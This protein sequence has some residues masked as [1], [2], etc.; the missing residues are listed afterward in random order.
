M[1]ESDTQISTLLYTAFKDARRF[2]FEIAASYGLTPAQLAAL[3]S[4]WKNDGMKNTELGDQLSLK[5]STVTTLADRME[6]DGLVI[7]KRSSA[8]R[9][10]VNIWLTPKG[11]ELKEMVPDIEK[12]VVKKMKRHFN[13]EEF[14]ELARLLQK[15]SEALAKTDEQA[16]ST[17]K[18]RGVSN[19]NC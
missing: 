5:T 19:G 10:A 13:N 9:R 15:F 8:D 4:L 17:W 2:F 16:V 14:K 11:K 6:R 7:R 1:D 3:N 12:L 18:N